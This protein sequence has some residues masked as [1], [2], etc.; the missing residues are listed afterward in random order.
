MLFGN[1]RIF[2]K[3]GLILFISHILKINTLFYFCS[4]FLGFMRLPEKIFNR[5]LGFKFNDSK[6]FTNLLENSSADFIIFITSGRDNFHF[7][8]NISRKNPK[9]TY[10]MIIANWDGPSSKNIISKNF[11]SFQDH[12]SIVFNSRKNQ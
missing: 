10:I 4:A 8:F 3:K 11:D 6:V 9:T 1:Y 5:L 2:N 12:K 7:L